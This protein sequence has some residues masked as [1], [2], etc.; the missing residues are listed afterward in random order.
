[1]KQPTVYMLASERNGT[2][3]VGVTSD[4][5]ARTWQHKEHAV[6]GFTKQYDVTMLVWYELHGQMESAIQREKQIKAWKREWK[7]RL[8]EE[9]NPYWKDLWPDVIG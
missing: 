1:M 3:Y 5:I 2:L 7:M 6:D 9:A 8:I 4:L